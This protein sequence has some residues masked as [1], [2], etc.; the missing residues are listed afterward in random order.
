MR[1]LAICTLIS[2]FGLLLL[3]GCVRVPDKVDV[4]AD[5]VAGYCTGSRS[6]RTR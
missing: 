5:V 3:S 6:Q 4:K 1:A 2:S